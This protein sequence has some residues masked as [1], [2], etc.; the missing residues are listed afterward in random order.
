[1]FT[2]EIYYDTG[3]SFTSYSEIEKIGAV[4]PT[5]EMAQKALFD[6]EDHFSFLSEVENDKR[7]HHVLGDYDSLKSKVEDLYAKD[8]YIDFCDD[9]KEDFEEIYNNAESKEL[10]YAILNSSHWQCY[11]KVDCGEDE[12][13][14]IRA[15]WIGFFEHPRTAK[16][17]VEGKPNEIVFKG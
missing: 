3:D 14:E 16:I 1:M 11:L 8:W 13:R 6:I 7:Y 4:F 5:L 10:M 2:I 15:F 17:V 12:P 9:D